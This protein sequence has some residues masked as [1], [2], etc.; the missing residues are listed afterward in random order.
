MTNYK[1][2]FG[3]AASNE[4]T[5]GYDAVYALVAAIK[6]ANASDRDSIQK[7]L[8]KLNISTPLGTQITFSNPPNGENSTAAVVALR[9]VGSGTFEQV[10][11]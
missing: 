9:V 1:A 2:R 3:L 11:P 5:Q 8:A 7:A 4:A 6:S 10:T